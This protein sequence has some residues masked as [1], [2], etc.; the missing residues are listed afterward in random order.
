MIVIAGD[1]QHR[2][3][4]AVQQRA[5]MCV[6]RQIAGPRAIGQ[7]V[8]Q[9]A[10]LIGPPLTPREEELLALLPTFATVEELAHD[11]QIS[12][13]TV[14]THIRGIYRKLGVGTR[15]EAIAAAGRLGLVASSTGPVHVLRPS[16]V[17]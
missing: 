6:A 3:T 16:T 2:H 10:A 14:K 8:P 1:V 15:R 9:P 5:E 12:T 7:H 13:N 17:R 4:G 11:L